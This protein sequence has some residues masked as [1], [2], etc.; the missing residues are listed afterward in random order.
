M[1]IHHHQAENRKTSARGSRIWAALAELA[2]AR[3]L[4]RDAGCDPWQFAVEIDVLLDLGITIHDLRR[5]AA[6]GH[7]NHAREITQPRDAGRKYLS[8]NHWV[9]SKK[10]CFILSN[11]ILND[12]HTVFEA[13]IPPSRKR[14]TG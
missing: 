14:L 7:V 13:S 6:K 10:T 2:K 3:D 4:A 8:E 12:M 11:S 9:F 5:L 1:K